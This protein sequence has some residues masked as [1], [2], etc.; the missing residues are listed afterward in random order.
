MSNF[1]KS[2]NLIYFF[3]ALTQEYSIVS[4]LLSAVYLIPTFE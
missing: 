3:E 2:L 4:L 1:I